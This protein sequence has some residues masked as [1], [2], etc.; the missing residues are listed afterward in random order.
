LQRRQSPVDHWSRRY[1]FRLRR[2]ALHSL[3][4]PVLLWLLLGRSV[5]RFL[6]VLRFPRVLR[7]LRVRVRRLVPRFL[8]VLR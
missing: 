3:K 8:L 5:R 4:W 2:Q 1:V 7:F 6:R